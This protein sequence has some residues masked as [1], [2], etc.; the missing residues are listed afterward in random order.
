MSQE[1]S[2]NAP[3]DLLAPQEGKSRLV[4]VLASIVAV[5][6]SV[7]QLAT[8]YFGVLPLM[9]Q[10]PIHMAFGF[11]LVFLLFPALRSSGGWE[12]K[13]G[14]AA[15]AVLIAI[16]VGL[17]A[18]IAWNH[19]DIEWRAGDYYDHE[20]FFGVVVILLVL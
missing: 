8:S 18:Y 11:S 2:Q 3:E 5:V 15:D 17:T 14:R 10:R 16:T 9:Q 13:L 6:W 19:I 1:V 7:F 20:I 12:R 4:W